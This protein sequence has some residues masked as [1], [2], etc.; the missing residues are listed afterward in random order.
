MGGRAVRGVGGEKKRKEVE[1]G[2]WEIA[3]E[4]QRRRGV[5]GG[6][7][8]FPAL[9]KSGKRGRETPGRAANQETHPHT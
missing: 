6:G 3:M 7:R 1:R 9:K 4:L 8:V 2:F 5:G